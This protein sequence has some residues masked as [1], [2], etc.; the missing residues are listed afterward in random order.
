MIEREFIK[1]KI[2]AL[3]IRREVDNSIKKVAGCGSIVIEKTPLGEKIIIHAV[4]P[5]L[6]IGRGG[7][8]IKGL[9]QTL[10]SKFQLENPQIEV[11]EIPRAFLNAQ[12]VAKKIADDL[13]RF[14]SARFKIIGYRMLREIMN[15]GAMGA[16]LRI[17][18]R[19]LPSKRSRTWR[20]YDGYLKK[21]G[22]VSDE[23]V[24]VGF[25][26]ANLK[27]GAIGILI[28]IMHADTPL[29]DR[30]NIIAPKEEPA[31]VKEA[32]QEEPAEVKEAPKKE[33]K[34]PAAKPKKPAA[35]KPAVKAKPK[36]TGGK[37]RGNTKSK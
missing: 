34:K 9:T 14:G 25:E 13:E 16:E 4:R 21:S 11:S 36:K 17:S 7:E 35:K 12:T 33:K 15:S 37:K 29:P 31:E 28:R 1:S 10:K 6:V 8:T 32:P 19:G 30:V 27:S 26:T 24:D 20:F 3:S 22:Y 23:K 5:G 2:K 18:G